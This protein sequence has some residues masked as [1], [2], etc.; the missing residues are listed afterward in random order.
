MRILIGVYDHFIKAI[1]TNMR[2]RK[3]LLQVIICISALA[4]ICNLQ[5]S[6][7]SFIR[8]IQKVCVGEINCDVELNQ[9][10]QLFQKFS[11]ITGEIS[12]ILL[13]QLL[14]L[15]LSLLSKAVGF[16]FTQTNLHFNF[17]SSNVIEHVWAE[18]T[19]QV[20]SIR[21]VQMQCL[22][23]G[24]LVVVVNICLVSNSDIV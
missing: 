6:Q 19:I 12:P 22:E 5:L 11:V 14:K 17:Q 13:V 15:S 20:K 4:H 9:V 21:S 8:K 16:N 7:L 24:E 23:L 1:L 18:I 3:N 2:V 10:W